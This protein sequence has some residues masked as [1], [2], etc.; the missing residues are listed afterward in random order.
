MSFLSRSFL[1]CS[2]DQLLA[3]RATGRYLFAS[4]A[5]N[6]LLQAAFLS[7]KLM[8]T[9]HSSDEWSDV[10]FVVLVVCY[11]AWIAISATGGF[12]GLYSAHK[13]DTRAAV[14]CLYAWVLLVAFQVVEAIVAVYVIIP[15]A[16]YPADAVNS[17]MWNTVSLLAIEVL[18]I[19]FIYGYIQLLELCEPAK[20][21]IQQGMEDVSLM[22]AAEAL[23]SPSITAHNVK[24]YGTDS[25]SI[26]I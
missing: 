17:L 10:A 16:H 18:F 8:E 21:W 1:D 5:A 11:T 15:E 14:W 7:Y 6:M 19:V 3:L 12:L 25:Q 9:V 2:F 22:A 26:T 20:R 13:Y 4:L 23:T 24:S